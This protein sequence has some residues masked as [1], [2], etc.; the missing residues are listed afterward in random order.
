MIMLNCRDTAQLVSESM[1]HRLPWQRRLQ[2][3]IHLFMCDN[4]AR[5]KK[6][7]R[8]LRQIFKKQAEPQAD[9]S[10]PILNETVKDRLRKL[11]E[12]NGSS[13]E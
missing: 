2:V 7:L 6:Q 4:C 8:L 1:D 3:R 12:D 9:D 11:V 10:S 5:Y 13:P